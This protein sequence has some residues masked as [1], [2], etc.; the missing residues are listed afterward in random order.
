MNNLGIEDNMLE[1]IIY[2]ICETHNSLVEQYPEHSEYISFKFEKIQKFTKLFN[3]RIQFII[4]MKTP[5]NKKYIEY[6]KEEF[7][8]IFHKFV[9]KLCLHLRNS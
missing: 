4:D 1:S 7:K 2:A 9:I 5:E 8:N 6:I 3:S